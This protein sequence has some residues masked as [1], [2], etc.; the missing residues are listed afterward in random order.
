MFTFYFKSF[1]FHIGSINYNNYLEWGLKPMYKSLIIAFV[2][3]YDLSDL[4]A[5]NSISKEELANYKK[6]EEL[7]CVTKSKE[8]LP[9]A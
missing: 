6:A 9:Y 2:L 8:A 7:L 3:L 1:Q 5:Q 4:I